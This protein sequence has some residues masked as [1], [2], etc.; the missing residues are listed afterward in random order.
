M[1]LLLF[2]LLCCGLLACWFGVV[3]MGCYVVVVLRA[4]LFVICVVPLVCLVVRLC[5]VVVCCV[6]T[7]L[8]YG[9]VGLLL[10]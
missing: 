1:C 7:L 10:C 5:Y 4:D 6:V 8:Y 3:L 9:F 2:V